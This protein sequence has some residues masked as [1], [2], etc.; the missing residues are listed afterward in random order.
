M[1]LQYLVGTPAAKDSEGVYAIKWN[2]TQK[3]GG[4]TSAFSSPKP[5]GTF[6]PS[7]PSGAFREVTGPVTFKK[8]TTTRTGTFFGALMGT[9]PTGAIMGRVAWDDGTEGTFTLGAGARRCDM[10]LT[11]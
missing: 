5:T 1:T 7:A 11:F 10:S 4:G 3:E 8:G 9:S 2:T 6:K